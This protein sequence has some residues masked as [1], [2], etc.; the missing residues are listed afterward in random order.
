M[1]CLSNSSKTINAGGGG[2]GGVEDHKCRGREG[3]IGKT[4]V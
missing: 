4:M 2:G 1:L 3:G